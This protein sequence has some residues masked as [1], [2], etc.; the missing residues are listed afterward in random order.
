LD[1]TARLL[2]DQIYNINKR[3]GQKNLGQ[4]SITVSR[5]SLDVPDIQIDSPE[6]ITTSYGKSDLRYESRT[7]RESLIEQYAYRENLVNEVIRTSMK[8]YEKPIEARIDFKKLELY[9]QMELANN[10]LALPFRYA[11][12]GY[13]PDSVYWKS[14]GYDL[15]A[16][17]NVFSQ[18]LFPKDPAPAKS[19]TLLV[20]F[21]AERNSI[22]NSVRFVI[23]SI[24]FTFFLLVVFAVTLWI[25]LRQKRLSEMKKDF[26]NNMTHE[27]KTPVA[28][29]SIAAQMLSDESMIN[30]LEKGGPLRESA[31]FNKITRTIGDE[32]KRLHFLIDKVLQMSLMDDGQS[33]MKIKEVDVNDLLLNVVQI[34]DIQVE[35]CG[36][37][38]ELEPEAAESVVYVDEMHF[39]NVLFNL[40]ENAVKYR[41][42]DVPL[43]LCART[44][45]VADK[46]TIS[47]SDN[48]TGIKKENLK[49]I[50]DRFYRVSTGNVHNVKGFGLG[51]AYV[52]KI[53]D[54]L[55]GTIKVESELNAGTKFIISL[56][57]V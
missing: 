25:V 20:A 45:N 7:V 32:T 49:K 31:S 27:L 46:I 3:V 17:G 6:S 57:Y 28:S 10:N 12:K 14:P 16:S 50:F 5:N 43:R 56:P 54:E 22:F 35:K 36:G 39:T 15:T 34:F 53:I 11:I 51:L 1:E 47:I 24:V 42:P 33:I 8:A 38:L 4:K 23:P 19:Y 21:P 48:G 55:N 30:M 37:T 18:V 13:N 52:K 9:I 2:Q 29:I 40:M 41:R 44:E 26:I